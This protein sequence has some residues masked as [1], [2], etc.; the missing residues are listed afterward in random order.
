MAAVAF[1]AHL[2][3]L[4]LK[5]FVERI[6]NR[7]LRC[8]IW[9][10]P[11]RGAILSIRNLRICCINAAVIVRRRPRQVRA[12]CNERARDL[13]ARELRRNSRWCPPLAIRQVNHS[14]HDVL[15]D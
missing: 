3:G 11:T 15:L 6:M 14:L 5:R 1:G 13:H 2:A 8:P 9:I 12:Q 7:P 4:R 10:E